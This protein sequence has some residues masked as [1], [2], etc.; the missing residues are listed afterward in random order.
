MLTKD[1]YTREITDLEAKSTALY[2]ETVLPFIKSKL[3]SLSLYNYED[4]PKGITLNIDLHG[5]KEVSEQV[6]LMLKKDLQEAGYPYIEYDVHDLYQGCFSVEHF[7]AT[8]DIYWDKSYRTSNYP[9]YKHVI[10]QIKSFLA[11]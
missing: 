5:T 1:Q 3:E 11:K 8:L 2:N 6:M 7:G 4:E 10:D 9:W